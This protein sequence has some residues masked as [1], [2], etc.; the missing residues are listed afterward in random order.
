M[1]NNCPYNL[2][3][4]LD[5]SD[6]KAD[7]HFLQT[8]HD[9]EWTATIGTSPEALSAWHEQLQ[10]DHP[11]ARIGLVIEQPAGAIL[12]FLEGLPGLTVHAINPVMLQKFREAFVLSRAKD[13]AK[14]AHY[15]AHLLA[16]HSERVPRWEPEDLQTRQLQQLVEHRRGVVDERTRLTNT[17]KDLLKRHFPQALSLCG[18][19]LWRPLAVAFLQRWPTLEQARRARPETLR[20]FYHARGS[21]SQKLIDHRLDILAQAV[22]LITEGALLESYRLR[23][24]CL[25]S[26]L[27]VLNRTL[28]QYDQR[29]A[30]AFACH[31]DQEIFASFPGAGPTFAPRLLSAMGARRERH[32]DAGSLQR[33]SGIA[34]VTKQSGRSRCTQYR[35][36]CPKFIRQSFHE[37]ARESLLH[38]RWAAAYYLQQRRQ[39]SEHHS[40]VRALAFKWQRVMYRC[41]QD[42]ESYDDA[43]YEAVLKKR[44]SPI[45]ELFEEIELGKNPYT[46]EQ[47]KST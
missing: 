27:P 30:E 14:D 20:A 6:Q 22:D 47:K 10:R 15:L 5:R 3:I 4:G 39:G 37:Y 42:H 29:I 23:L 36:H 13:D 7:L 2:V 43:R 9:R 1:K 18:D 11:Q 32:V 35:Y 25:C 45:S 46:Q 40:A 17:L 24:R 34:P 26:Q 21:R 31:P 19:D 41:W 16:A 12:A 8:D 28:A 44:Q 33:Y 38:C